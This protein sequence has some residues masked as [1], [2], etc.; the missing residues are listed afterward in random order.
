M[1]GTL[2]TLTRADG[3]S[4][5]TYNGLPLYGWRIAV[6]TLINRPLQ[7]VWDFSM[8]LSNSSQ[9]TASGS[10]LRQT[11]TGPPGVANLKRL[12]ERSALSRHD[13]GR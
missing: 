13:L 6:S 12:I 11:S 10:E 3:N 1:T 4:Q 5:V 8:D 7:E 2:G 9:W